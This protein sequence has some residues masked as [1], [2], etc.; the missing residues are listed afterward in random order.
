MN[1]IKR[2]YILLSKD[3]NHLFDNLLKLQTD[4][5]LLDFSHF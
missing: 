1:L 5:S 2:D 3:I 4:S